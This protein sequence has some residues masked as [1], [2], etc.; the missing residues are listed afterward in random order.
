MVVDGEEV[1]VVTSGQWWSVSWHPPDREPVGTRHG[2]QAVCVTGD[3]IVLV[4]RDGVAW[5]LS[6]G[7]PE[8]EES[9]RATLVREV[10]EEACARVVRCRL[11]G[12]VSSLCVDGNQ[13]GLVLVR[14]MWRADVR[15]DDWAPQHE[16]TARRVVC[17]GQVAD[18]LGLATHPFAAVVRRQLWE[19]GFV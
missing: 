9:W 11:L 1:V 17:A 4:S 16:M 12:F 18:V 6:A 5:E 19:A 13:R 14:S 2:A 7:R 3:G 15:L 8:G 10:A